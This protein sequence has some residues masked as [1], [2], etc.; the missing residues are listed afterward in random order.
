M[1]DLTG[2]QGKGMKLFCNQ[3]QGITQVSPF[4]WAP[5]LLYSTDPL[6]VC[7]THGST[8]ATA[9]WQVAWLC[10]GAWSNHC[11]PVKYCRPCCGTWDRSRTLESSFWHVCLS[12]SQFS[13][14]STS[15]EWGVSKSWRCKNRELSAPQTHKKS[16]E[17]QRIEIWF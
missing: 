14:D 8:E 7:K 16:V 13:A 15:Q 11:R 10:M 17:E 9:Q 6:T 5:S 1:W 12:I 2:C 4:V 3:G